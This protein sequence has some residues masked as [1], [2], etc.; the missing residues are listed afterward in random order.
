[1]IDDI[2]LT[3]SFAIHLKSTVLRRRPVD[4]R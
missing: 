4:W 3:Y 1:M 2:H